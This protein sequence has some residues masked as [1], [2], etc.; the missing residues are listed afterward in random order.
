MLGGAI[1][2]TVE[3][4]AELRRAGMRLAALS[5][6]SAEKFPIATGALPVPR[7]VRDRSSCPARSAVAKPDARIFR[8]PARATGLDAERTLFI[9]DAPANVAAATR[10]GIRAV[11]FRD[12]AALRGDL[13]AIGLLPGSGS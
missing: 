11:P 2:G 1:D 9:D 5:N 10:L 13:E 7:L 12:P 3:V 6:W 4:L 8:H